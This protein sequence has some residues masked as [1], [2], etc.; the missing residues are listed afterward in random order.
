MRVLSGETAAVFARRLW[1]KTRGR[2]RSISREIRANWR[3]FAIDLVLVFVSLLLAF[4]LRF[5][6]D[7]ERMDGQEIW[8]LATT[9]LVV[10]AVIFPIWRLYRLDCRS[11]SL[12][13]LVDL[14]QAVCVAILASICVLFMA[15]MLDQS[16]RSVFVIQFL[17]LAPMM[18]L[19]RLY[20]R[21]S[22]FIATR[23]SES[24]VA[25]S[26]RL[27]VLL[28]GT[29]TPCD[30][31][32]R[33]LGR[34]TDCAY[35]PVGIIDNR[36][37]TAGLFFHN[38]PILGSLSEIE[39]AVS[40]LRGTP[41][42]PKRII[43]TEPLGSIATEDSRA[44]IEWAET[45]GVAVSKLPD[46]A[47]LKSVEQDGGVELQPIELTDLLNRPQNVIDR[48]RLE[49]MADGRRILVTGAGG[50]IGSEL[51]R[52]L[53]K[54]GPSELVLIENGEYNLYAIE[55]ELR[56]AGIDIPV[57]AYIADVRDRR[58]VLSIFEAHRPEIVFHAA[59]LKHV[60][61]VERHPCEGVLTNIIGTRNI[62]AA[63]RAVESLAMVQISTD[64]AVNTTN[65]MGAS[66]RVAEM[67]CQALDIEGV[68][69]GA[70]QTRFMTVRFGNVLGSSGSLIPLFQKQIAAGGPLTVTHPDMQRF[71]MTIREA[72]EL[73]LNASS[74]G[75]ADGAGQG[76]IFVLDMGEPIRI[77]DLAKRM[78]RLAGLRPDED[79]E[80][81]IVGMRPGEKLFEELFD[82]K[83]SR[84]ACAVPGVMTATSMRVDVDLLE[85]AILQLEFAARRQKAVEVVTRLRDLVPGYVGGSEW[86]DL[87]VEAPR[88]VAKKPLAA[89]SPAAP[90]I[91]FVA[92]GGAA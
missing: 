34:E 6:A 31:F 38:T 26:Q 72:V 8:T 88:L 78:I 81:K 43:L 62:A 69:R 60:P 32:L 22:D 87:P 57:S 63:A 23:R 30:L 13:D 15:S 68:D 70:S 73:T 39:S 59:A 66:K 21:R 92:R 51:V 2:L 36:P 14:A 17:T 58:R 76:E 10:A 79:I 74:Y 89:A 24:D 9:G 47:H 82:R 4:A 75:L 67:Y 49:A 45:S 1:E 48:K 42:F 20:H 11:T 61:M 35:R 71:F 25:T 84:K 53:S 28:V 91:P 37:K 12:R 65:V 16:P 55:T 64:K 27:P 18:A 33:K 50:S 56:H 90:A 5:E 7:M 46:L 85:D 54:L 19:V 77:M 83:E 80:I 3:L 52:Q 29:G 44:L 40:G 86:R 41:D